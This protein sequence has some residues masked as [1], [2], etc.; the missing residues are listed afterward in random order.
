MNKDYEKCINEIIKYSLLGYQRNLTIADS[1]NVSCR[2]RDGIL[3]TRSKSSLGELT[4]KDILYVSMD[5][6]VLEG[7]KDAVPS[8]ETKMHLHLY[9]NRPDVQ[10]VYHVHPPYSTVYAVK[11]KEIPFLTSTSRRKIGRAPLVPYADPGSDELAMYVEETIVGDTEKKLNALLLEK[12]GIMTFADSIGKSFQLAE[13]L[14]I[15]A[16]IALLERFA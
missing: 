10:C 6:S 8:K 9:Q 15:T 7:E 14:E 16:K 13:L 5:G 12:H 1:G 2:Y 3:V 4:D 11:G